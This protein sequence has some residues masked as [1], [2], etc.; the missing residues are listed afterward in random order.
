MHLFGLAR[1]RVRGAM[2]ALLGIGL[3]DIDA[4]EHLERFGPLTQRDL[5]DRLLLSSGAITLLVDR[6]ERLGL[7]RRTPHLSD[8]RMTLVELLPEAAL[9]ELPEMAAYHA[10]LA[11]AAHSLSPAARGEIVAFLRQLQQHADAATEAMRSRTFPRPRA[12]DAGPRR[13]NR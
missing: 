5:G 4:L 6:L 12:T 11:A 13:P 10:D 9:P 8:R 3:T 7:V 1:D 2:A